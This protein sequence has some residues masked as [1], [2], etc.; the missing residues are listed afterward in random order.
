MT[1]KDYKTERDEVAE[2]IQRM[3]LTSQKEN[4]FK[5]GPPLHAYMLT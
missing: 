5:V 1:E 4:A 3:G 2:I